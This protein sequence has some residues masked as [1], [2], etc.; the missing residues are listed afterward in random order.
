MAWITPKTDWATNEGIGTADLN[1]MEGNSA[2]LKPIQD[3]LYPILTQIKGTATLSGGN[4][5]TINNP[6]TVGGNFFDVGGNGGGTVSFITTLNVI[7][8]TIIYIRGSGMVLDHDA[9]NP[10]TNFA[11]I[12]CNTL[13]DIT[14]GVAAT[15]GPY[16]QGLAILVYDGTYWVVVGN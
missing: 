3:K 8:G 16:R 14:L 15:P 11:A 5:L 2:Y 10:A 1:R 9:L 6:T 13:A 4:E 7:P 12:W